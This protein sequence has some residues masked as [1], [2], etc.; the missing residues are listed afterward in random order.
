MHLTVV[1]FGLGGLQEVKLSLEKM[2][3]FV[4]PKELLTKVHGSNAFWALKATVVFQ[5]GELL[6]LHADPS[7][8]G[9]LTRSRSGYWSP[10]LEQRRRLNVFL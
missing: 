6:Q 8:R 4:L 5:G 3:R 2:S 7:G 9:V 1:Y 10:R